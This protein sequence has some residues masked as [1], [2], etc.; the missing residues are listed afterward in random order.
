MGFIDTYTGSILGCGQHWPLCNGEVVPG[1]WNAATI[2]E[3]V[4]RLISFTAIMLLFVFTALAGWRHYASR[5]VRALISF[6]I[7]AVIMEAGLG[8]ISVLFSS[9]PWVLAFHMG[10]AFTSFSA[11]IMLT[12][13]V[14]RIE[15]KK[16]RQMLNLPVAA[17]SVKS[18][19]VKSCLTFLT[20][21]LAIYYG[22]F[23]THSGYGASFFGWPF[24][25]ETGT[26]WGFWI[27]AVHRL[28]ALLLLILD[29]YLVKHAYQLRKI[30]RDLFIGSL[31]TLG[32]T[33]LQMFSGAYMILSHMSLLSFMIH[34]SFA[35]F[36]FASAAFVM[37]QAYSVFYVTKKDKPIKPFQMK[38]TRL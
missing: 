17:Y 21:F 30:K 8:A 9:P 19:F 18:F 6:S 14:K 29:I 4:H 2:I 3:Y 15:N 12:L 32:F 20:V 5:K 27:D 34:V 26:G 13:A 31:F 25:Q 16:R 28:V 10:I 1:K 37:L 36:L 7:I 23:V 24:P 33:V 38:V 22:A 35:S 11:C